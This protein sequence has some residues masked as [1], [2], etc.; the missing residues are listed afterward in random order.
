MHLQEFVF[1][2]IIHS[3]HTTL[4]VTLFSS[5]LYVNVIQQW[6]HSYCVDGGRIGSMCL[7]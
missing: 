7:F 3:S 4:P 2:K 6:D 5:L 1:Y